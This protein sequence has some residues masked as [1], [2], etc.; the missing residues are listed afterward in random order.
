VPGAVEKLIEMLDWAGVKIDEGKPV[1]F[2]L[3]SFNSRLIVF[4]ISVT[5]EFSF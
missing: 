4:R 1:R 2:S 5:Q 3:S